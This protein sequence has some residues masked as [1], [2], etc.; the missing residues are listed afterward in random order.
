MKKTNI[1]LKQICFLG[2]VFSGT[3]MGILSAEST[4]E[5][6]VAFWDTNTWKVGWDI[7]NFVALIYLFNRFLTPMLN[8]A[9]EEGIEEIE[10]GLGEEERQK[11]ALKLQ[12]EELKLKLSSLDSQK[13][14]ELDQADLDAIAIKKEILDGAR[15]L[16]MR[17]IDKVEVDAL[18]YFNLSVQAV[19]NAFTEKV[20]NGAEEQIKQD[21]KKSDLG[22][23]SADLI[24]GL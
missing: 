4:T 21:D 8:T 1:G 22:T 3:S 19:K 12:A 23:Y 20:F 17:T 2:L 7:I 16:E 15:K 11:Q 9:V 18:G 24:K 10:V 13:K 5:T 6:S 14:S